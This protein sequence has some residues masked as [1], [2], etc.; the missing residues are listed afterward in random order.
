MQVIDMIGR[1]NHMCYGLHK[2]YEKLLIHIVFKWTIMSLQRVLPQSRPDL[3]PWLL[4][5][6]TTHCCTSTNN[7]GLQE[8][9]GGCNQCY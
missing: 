7:P 4:W 6:P 2:C 1:D 3:T 8:I 5:V 9:M